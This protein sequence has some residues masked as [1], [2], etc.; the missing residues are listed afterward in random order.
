MPTLHGMVKWAR[1][2]DMVETVAVR[3]AVV[4]V[5]VELGEPTTDAER[6]HGT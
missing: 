3:R 4:E 6:V 1:L 2:Q 5:W